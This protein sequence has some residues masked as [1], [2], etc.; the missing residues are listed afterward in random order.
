MRLRRGV[1]LSSPPFF[2]VI[3]SNYFYAL[4]SVTAGEKAST[5]EML[6]AA[7]IAGI[8]G[9]IAGNPAG[10]FR[11]RRSRYLLSLLRANTDSH[12]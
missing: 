2:P 5:W 8:A 9:G 10:E 4:V 12:G 6:G 1:S 3:A 7:T 11:A